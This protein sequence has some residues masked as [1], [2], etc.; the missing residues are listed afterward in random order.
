MHRLAI[1]ENGVVINA[2]VSPTLDHPGMV[3]VTAQPAVGPGWAY[4]GVEFS[5]PTP[6]D[7]GPAPAVYQIT[8]TELL[9]RFTITEKAA[10]V[11]AQSTDPIVGAF[12]FTLQAARSIDSDNQDLIDGVK[13]MESQGLIAVGRA[14]EILGQ[15]YE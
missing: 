2:I 12:M 11:A 15:N 7:P 5:A 10:I 1:I 6:P 14:A 3:D 9:R 8:P 4:D 13:Y